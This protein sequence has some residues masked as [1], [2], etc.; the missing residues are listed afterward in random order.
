M[1]PPSSQGTRLTSNKTAHL[2]K[3][4]PGGQGKI[5]LFF[6][7]KKKETQIPDRA[8]KIWSPSGQGSKS[9]LYRYKPIN[10]KIWL[11]GGQG[12]KST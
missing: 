5:P 10:S 8:T 11:P 7:Y 9:T 6:N 2:K 3:W 1:F 12:T 4:P